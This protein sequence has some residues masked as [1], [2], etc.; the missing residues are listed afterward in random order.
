MKASRRIL[1][2]V[3]AIYQTRTLRA[4]C[5]RQV[6]DGPDVWL[7]LSEI[8]LED[9]IGTLFAGT[10]PSRGELVSVTAPE[11]LLLEKGLL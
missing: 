6:E 1:L 4:V 3:A 7:P 8:T 10:P 5:V 2:T 9:G 11:W